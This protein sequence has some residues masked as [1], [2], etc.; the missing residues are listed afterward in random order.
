[1]GQ[2]GGYLGNRPHRQAGHQRRPDPVPGVHLARVGAGDGSQSAGD[3][4]GRGDPPGRDDH[5]SAVRSRG[6]LPVRSLELVAAAAARAAAARRALA[7]AGRPGRRGRAVSDGPQGEYLRRVSAPEHLSVSASGLRFGA[8]A[9]GDPGAPLAL[10]VH[11]YPDSAWTWR[12]IGP[13]LAER[14][15]RAVAPFSRG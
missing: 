1:L 6:R 3:R 8:L 4:P 12:H 14:S 13:Y 10:L 9:W 2:P 7:T 15:W 11:G 5:P